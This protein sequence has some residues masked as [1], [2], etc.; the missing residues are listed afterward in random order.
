MTALATTMFVDR[1][2]QLRVAVRAGDGTRTPLLL[3]NGLGASMQAFQ[4][5]IDALDPGL[6]VICFDVPGMG[7]SPVPTWPYRLPALARLVGRMLDELGHPQVD[8]LG[9]SWGGG[10]AQQFAFTERRRCR[11]L[12]LVAT[13]PG[14]MFMVPPSPAVQVKMMT[15]RR[16]RDPDYLRRVG[17]SL[18][19]GTVRTDPD[20]FDLVLDH[21]SRG[22][23]RTGWRGYGYQMLAGMGWTS[24]A[25][26]H[27]LTQPTLVL[28]GDDD[29]IMPLANGRI[30]ARRIPGAKLHVYTGGHLELA[31]RP[32]LLVPAIE[33]FLTAGEDS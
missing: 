22:G 30:L 1:D 20:S 11:R 4:P 24:I 21:L 25:F 32:D 27:R 29:P 19:G 7:E 28:A 23:K 3:M 18:Y 15:P 9:I 10:L 31:A 12:V 5:L 8:V 26:L 33:A 6:T 17:P 14:P 2:K 13:C 16:Y